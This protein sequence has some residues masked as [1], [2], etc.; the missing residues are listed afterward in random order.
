MEVDQFS[1]PNLFLLKIAANMPKPVRTIPTFARQI[2]VLPF[3]TFGIFPTTTIVVVVV[4]GVVVVAVVATISASICG[5]ST[6]ASAIAL[7]SEPIRGH[8]NGFLGSNACGRRQ[9]RILGIV[10][11]KHLFW[12]FFFYLKKRFDLAFNKGKVSAFFFLGL[13]CV[14]RNDKI[15]RSPETTSCTRNLHLPTITNT[16]A[17]THTCHVCATVTA[18]HAHAEVHTEHAPACWLLQPR[19]QYFPTV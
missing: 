18:T 14:E 8:Y 7:S 12:F 1:P 5:S 19:A 2:I 10:A 16:S 6:V 15:C 4:G 11:P 17:C 13:F 3:F 9:H